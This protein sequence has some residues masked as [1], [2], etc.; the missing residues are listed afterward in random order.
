MEGEL[1]NDINLSPNS[2]GRSKVTMYEANT[3][4]QGK[5]GQTRPSP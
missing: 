3:T 1:G 2:G 4:T 5:G